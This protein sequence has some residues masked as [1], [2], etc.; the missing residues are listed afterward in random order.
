MNSPSTEVSGLKGSC[1]IRQHRV[2]TVTSSFMRWLFL[3]I[4]YTRRSI[5]TGSMRWLQEGKMY[6]LR[7]L[8]WLSTALYTNNRLSR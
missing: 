2:A 1:L 7:R 3:S 8:R 4:L 6:S 5:Q